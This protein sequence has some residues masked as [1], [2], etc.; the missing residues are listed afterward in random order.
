MRSSRPRSPRRSS[1]GSMRCA[2][3]GLFARRPRPD[4][5]A[6]VRGW[7]Q[8]LMALGDTDHVA[9]AELACH[10][11]GCPDLETVV[12]VTLAD[13]RRFVLRFPSPVA[14]VTEAD[15]RQLRPQLPPGDRP[16]PPGPCRGLT[17]PCLELAPQLGRWT[18]HRVP[19][20]TASA[21]ARL[22]AP[23][24]T[25][26]CSPAEVRHSVALHSQKHH[27]NATVYR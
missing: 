17:S 4:A 23:G 22:G 1:A 18:A 13:R 11:P 9:I 7:T 14:G 24:S 3:V 12:T 19:P 25:P 16:A 15:I 5:V 27:I 26:E 21:R 20:A 8:D 2:D 10:E 6:R